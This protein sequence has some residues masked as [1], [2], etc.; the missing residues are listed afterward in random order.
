[1]FSF[2]VNIERAAFFSKAA[3]KSC[4]IKQHKNKINLG[5]NEKLTEGRESK[6]KKSQPQQL[7][8][9]HIHSTVFPREDNK[10]NTHTMTGTQQL[11]GR[12]CK[13]GSQRGASWDAQIFLTLIFTTPNALLECLPVSSVSYSVQKFQQESV[14]YTQAL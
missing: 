12:T 2:R 4:C 10:S 7:F 8:G 9:E 6:R 13:Q 1:M 5:L 11:W 14:L 3:L